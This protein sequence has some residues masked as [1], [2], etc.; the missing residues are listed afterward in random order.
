MVVVDL[1]RLALERKGGSDESFGVIDIESDFA[2][3][4]GGVVNR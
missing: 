3:C 4:D 2:K 1:F